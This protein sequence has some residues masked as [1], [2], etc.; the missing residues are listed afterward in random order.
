M[1]L[2]YFLCNFYKEYCKD[3]QLDEIFQSTSIP[4]SIVE[5]KPEEQS[6]EQNKNDL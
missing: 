6:K 5:D 2:F 4:S 1:H 3:D